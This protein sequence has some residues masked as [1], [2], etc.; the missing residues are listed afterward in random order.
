MKRAYDHARDGTPLIDEGP[1]YTILHDADDFALY[2]LEQMNPEQT[3]AT[4]LRWFGSAFDF[5][6]DQNIA[7]TFAGWRRVFTPRVVSLN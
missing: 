1:A 5:Y 7:R 4:L 6:L 2:C 3:M